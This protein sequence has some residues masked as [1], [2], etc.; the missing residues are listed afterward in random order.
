MNKSTGKQRYDSVYPSKV[1]AC[2]W[3]VVVVRKSLAKTMNYPLVAMWENQEG[4]R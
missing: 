3:L 2:M 1:C 4:R